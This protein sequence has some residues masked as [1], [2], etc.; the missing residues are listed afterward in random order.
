MR[1]ASLVGALAVVCA[2]LASAQKGTNVENLSTKCKDQLSEIWILYDANVTVVDGCDATCLTECKETIEQAIYSTESLECPLQED[3]SRCMKY[4]GFAWVTYA[5]ECELFVYGSTS[6][7]GGEG[8]GEG[9]AGEGRRLLAEGEGEGEGDSGGSSPASSNGATAGPGCFPKFASINDFKLF[10][11]GVY[12]Y[13]SYSNTAGIC[14][15]VF[16]WIAMAAIGFLT[17]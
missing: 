3:I 17:R 12:P 6:S 2:I 8:E 5:E 16:F 10:V 14:L 15:S 4:Q 7:G 13:R 1:Q 9:E 11:R